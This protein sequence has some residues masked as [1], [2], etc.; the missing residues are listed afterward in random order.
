MEFRYQFYSNLADGLWRKLLILPLEHQL[1][2]TAPVEGH[3]DAVKVECFALVQDLRNSC[4]CQSIN[5]YLPSIL[6]SFSANSTSFSMFKIYLWELCWKLIKRKN[7]IPLW[8]PQGADS[9]PACPHRLGKNLLCRWSSW[10]WRVVA[11]PGGW[12]HS[13]LYFDYIKSD[14]DR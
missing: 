9:F 14:E 3:H 4:R 10:F 12:F 6:K 7:C 13:L 2:E 8:W 11:V 1:L 5:L